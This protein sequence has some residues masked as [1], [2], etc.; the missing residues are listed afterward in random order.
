MVIGIGTDIV[1]YSRISRLN[2]KF[3]IKFAKK[4]LSESEYLFFQN[5]A[6]KKQVQYL[7]NCFAAK[8]STAKALGTGFSNGVRIVDI[9]LSYDYLGCPIITLVNRAAIIFSKKGASQIN[10]SISHEK[11]LTIAFVIIS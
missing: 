1:D 6:K 10:I 2:Y 5:L 7:A 4:I 11:K 8:E 9:K 3:G